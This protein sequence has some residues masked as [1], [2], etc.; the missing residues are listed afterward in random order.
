MYILV[1][2]TAF[3]HQNSN[4]FFVELPQLKDGAEFVVFGSSS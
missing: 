1:I 3:C 2:I 4:S